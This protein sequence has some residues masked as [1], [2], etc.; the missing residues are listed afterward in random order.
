MCAPASPL[1]PPASVCPSL[2]NL[3][4]S[5]S[6][7]S[8]TYIALVQLFRVSVSASVNSSSSSHDQIIVASYARPLG[9]T[10]VAFGM[11]V[12]VMGESHP[13]S[14]PPSLFYAHMLTIRH[15]V[16]SGPRHTTI[17]PHPATAA[18]GSLP[19]CPPQCLYA[20]SLSRDPSRYCLWDPCRGALSPLCGCEL[21]HSKCA[22]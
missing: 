7:E 11:V 10:L 1:H 22:R 12:L 16:P 2:L 18:S 5:L 14:S 19:R 21:G 20:S 3:F 6:S 17:F 8:N 4:P 13:S 15:G 9:A